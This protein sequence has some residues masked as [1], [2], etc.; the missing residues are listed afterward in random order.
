MTKNTFASDNYAGVHPEIME[1]LQRANQGHAASYGAD[2]FTDRAVK[3]F[4]EYFGET[5]EVFFV[6]N[7]T[8]ANVLGLQAQTHSFHS[9]LCS[10]LAHINVDES[11]APEKFTGCKLIPV[12][13]QNGKIYPDQLEA[14][15]IRLDDQHHPQAKVISISQ[16][17]EYA[18]VYTVEEVKALS[19]VAKKYNLYLHMDG[20]RLANAAASLNTDFASFTRDA[21]VDVLSFGGTKNGMMFG[22]AVIFFKPELAGYFKFIR[23]QGMQ[24]HSKMRFISAQFEALLSNDLWK[25]SAIHSNK[26]AKLLE[27]ELKKISSVKIT[28][29]VD[30][31]GI[32]AI[33]PPAIIPELQQE[34]FFYIWNE[35]TSEVRLMCSFDTTE[36]DVRSFSE[37]LR[38]LT[39]R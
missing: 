13:T 35:K 1:A 10:E 32:F 22:E 11:T 17:T 3:K 5:A 25:R 38:S 24:L 28:Q 34:H 4:R 30:A 23:K 27:Q 18:T 26:M 9:V 21:G 14:R 12:P 16:T 7:G 6:Y 29:S 2:G 15:V 19:A 36:E 20:S 8:G 37:K 33:M 39:A 31:N